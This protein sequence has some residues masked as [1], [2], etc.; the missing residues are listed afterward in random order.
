MDTEEFEAAL[1]EHLPPDLREIVWM[2]LKEATEKDELARGLAGDLQWH[3][4]AAERLKKEIRSL[5]DQLA[6]V[7]EL[8]RRRRTIEDDERAATEKEQKIRLEEAAK[9]AD[10][11]HA[12]IDAA[13]GASAYGRG[14]ERGFRDAKAAGALGQAG[15]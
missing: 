15:N 13:F 8:T 12:L 7:P 10:E 1:E 2:R 14:Y 5:Q 11:L 4:E 9:R 3:K 6:E